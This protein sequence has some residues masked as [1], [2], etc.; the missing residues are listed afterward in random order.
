MAWRPL[1]PGMDHTTLVSLGHLVQSLP[2][3]V[4][5]RMFYRTL[6]RAPA[7]SLAAAEPRY[8]HSLYA[9]AWALKASNQHNNPQMDSGER[10]RKY[11]VKKCEWGL[12][13]FELCGE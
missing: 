8:G 11:L 6:I 13:N 10:M 9:E 4:V 12:E 5:S 1:G 3:V 2:S 7:A